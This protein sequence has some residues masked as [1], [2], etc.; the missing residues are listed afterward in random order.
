[1][2]FSWT[3]EANAVRDP[4]LSFTKTGRARTWLTVA[5]NFGYSGTDGKWVQTSTLYLDVTCWG[6]LAERV[7]GSVHKG[8]LVALDLRDLEVT[9]NEEYVNL[10]ATARNVSL[11]LR[12]TEAASVRTLTEA[13]ER[14]TDKGSAWE[15]LEPEAVP[16]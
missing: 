3:I 5:H 15:A 11:S 10:K 9:K 2:Q 1:M 6:D 16:F 4:E 13:V 8:D 12:F 14:G 7:A